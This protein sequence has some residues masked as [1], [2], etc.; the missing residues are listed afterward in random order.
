MKE[1]SI[2]GGTDMRKG[3]LIISKTGR[4]MLDADTVF[5]S[6]ERSFTAYI[7]CISCRASID[8]VS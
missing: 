2:K 5:G 6:R 7:H 1:I 4:R 8:I 3:K